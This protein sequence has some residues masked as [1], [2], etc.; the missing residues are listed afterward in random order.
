[1]KYKFLLFFLSITLQADQ[2]SFLFYNDFFA[3]TDK[4]F[5]NGVSAS[6]IDD[7]VENKENKD[8]NKF[9]RAV[10]SSVAKIPFIPL[11]SAKLHSAGISLSQIIITPSDTSIK[12][13]QY[14]DVPY[15]GYL[16]LNIYLFEWDKKSFTEFR[17]EGGV[18][19]EESGAKFMQN[20]FHEMIGN[21]KSKGWDTQLTTHYTMNLLFRYGEISWQKKNINGFDLDWF[22]HLGFQAGNFVTDLF[23][24]TIIRVGKNYIH[25]FNVHYPYL[26][27][28]ASLLKLNHEHHNLGYSLSLGLSTELLA[29]SYILD[30]AKKQGYQTGKR[31]L[32]AAFY[33]GVDLYYLRSKFT[34]FYQSHSPYATQ[35]KRGDI[36]G[37]FIYAYQF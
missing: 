4:H 35:Q 24:S 30:E 29:Y 20:N 23:G 11:N 31:V 21:H 33:A 32:N 37:G 2:F 16:A 12:T 34:F 1:M 19:G 10:Y 26:K 9:S 17:V 3:G 13:P 5:T 18:V 25:N 7:A 27:E 6:W 14:D 8:S 22:N 36:F 15:A 28:E